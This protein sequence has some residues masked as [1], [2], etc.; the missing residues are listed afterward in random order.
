LKFD[1]N[2]QKLLSSVKIRK[3]LRK[4]VR[5]LEKSKK[6]GMVQRKKM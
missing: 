2:L 5:R 4:M 6:S 1:E 3:K